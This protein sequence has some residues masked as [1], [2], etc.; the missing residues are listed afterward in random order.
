MSFQTL[1]KAKYALLAVIFAVVIIIPA[2]VFGSSKTI[3]VDGN[4]SGMEDGSYDHPYGS[5]SDALDHAKDGDEVYVHNG[6]YKE[7]ITIPKGV[8]VKGN[9]KD[10]GNVVISGNDKKSIVTMKHGS[11]LSFVT[12][13]GGDNGIYVAKDARAKLYDVVVT[14]ATHDGIHADTAP[15][16]K[17]HRL[18]AEKVEVRKSGQ[19][20]V[21]SEKRYVV[22]V[23]CNIHDNDSNGVDF[24]AGTQA[25]LESVTSNKNGG[26]GWKAILDGSEIWSRNNQFRENGREGVQIESFGAAGKFGVKTSKTVDN[27]RWG[28]AL[29][30]RNAAATG[31]WKNIF[32]EDNSS[33]GNHFGNVSPV[34]RAN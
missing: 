12:V 33:W 4:A 11:S 5:I 31:M 7:H 22:L 3:H 10:H 17:N 1:F 28:I 18:Y 26:S 15:R 34:I 8:T 16:D 21:F 13:K 2:V 29:V 19:A 27:G 25:W 32:L 30:A 6:E 20:G 24:V 9:A 14:G 23:N